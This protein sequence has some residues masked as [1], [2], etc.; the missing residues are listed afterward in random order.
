MSRD[1][2][3]AVL[4][5]VMTI[6]FIALAIASRWWWAMFAVGGGYIAYRQMLLATGTARRPDAASR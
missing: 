4:D 6:G 1:F 2:R 3:S 5:L